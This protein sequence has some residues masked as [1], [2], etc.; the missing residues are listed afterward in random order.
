[1]LVKD[2]SATTFTNSKRLQTVAVH[3]IVHSS[4]QAL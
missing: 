2:W 1:M 3:G 4:T